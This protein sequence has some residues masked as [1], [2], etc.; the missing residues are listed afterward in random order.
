M[1]ILFHSF[2]LEAMDRPGCSLRPPRVRTPW[3][4]LSSGSPCKWYTTSASCEGQRP[5]WT[6]WALC[7]VHYTLSSVLRRPPSGVKCKLIYNKS[8]RLEKWVESAH[9]FRWWSIDCLISSFQRYKVL[10]CLTVRSCSSNS[11]KSNTRGPRKIERV[12]KKS[13]VFWILSQLIECKLIFAMKIDCSQIWIH[14]DQI[15]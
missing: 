7:T 3:G 12:F 9:I 14:D 8:Y 4:H 15:Q 5:V 6:R 2:D 10:E 13:L 1:K 11:Q